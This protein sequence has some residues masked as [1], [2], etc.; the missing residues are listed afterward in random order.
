[1]LN[2]GANCGIFGG[3]MMGVMSSEVY[4]AFVAAG[5]PKAQAKAAAEAIPV[6]HHLA[7]KRDIIEIT[8]EVANEFKTLYRWLWG[9]GCQHRDAGARPWQTRFLVCERTVGHSQ[10][11]AERTSEFETPLL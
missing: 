5:A 4:E 7:T 10:L 6:S 8:A 9:H 11:R 2:F 3:G 1:M